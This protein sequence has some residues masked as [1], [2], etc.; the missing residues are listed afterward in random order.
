MLPALLGLRYG[1]ATAFV[2]AAA[3]H[4][5][6]LGYS[7]VH[8]PAVWPLPVAY[9]FGLLLIAMLCGEF[10][11]IWSE[12]I[13]QLERSNEYR[14]ARLAEFT[15]AFH[16][17]KTSHDRLE[18]TNAGNKAS[19]RSALLEVSTQIS[20]NVE[21]DEAADGLLKLFNSYCSVQSASMFAVTPGQPWS[22]AREVSR[23]GTGAELRPDDFVVRTALESGM[24]MSVDIT[25]T[26]ILKERKPGDPLLTVPMVDV[27]RNLHGFVVVTEMPFFAFT[28]SNLQLLAIIAAVISDYLASEPMTGPKTDTE[29]REFARHVLRCYNSHENY[30]LPFCLLVLGFSDQASAPGYVE[31]VISKTRGLDLAYHARA[32]DSHFLAIL[33][34][35]TSRAGLAQF[36][37]RFDEYL[38]QQ[39]GA[40]SDDLGIE[41][42]VLASTE[43]TDRAALPRFIGNLIGTQ[44]PLVLNLDVARS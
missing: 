28:Q 25:N 37:R 35:L 39:H 26:E 3:M 21:L 10:R 33:M 29:A 8:P 6:A 44:H 13:N 4:L 38:T 9:S 24:A 31:T 40:P 41:V 16:A 42:S 36:R 23:I 1:F 18:Q 17:L 15:H 43:L 7:F 22:D 27:Y 30:K 12:R 2:T 19:L 14:Q 11:D 32:D 5:A 20:A 34:P